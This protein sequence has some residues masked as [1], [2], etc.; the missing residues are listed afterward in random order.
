MNKIV[1]QGE[2][3]AAGTACHEYK[4]TYSDLVFSDTM[5]KVDTGSGFSTSYREQVA[6]P[7]ESTI[8]LGV[9]DFLPQSGTKGDIAFTFSY[10]NIE[11][12]ASP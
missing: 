7:V 11:K 5:K 8:C 10:G 12:L 6:A 4:V 3:T 9:R 2:R 1:Y